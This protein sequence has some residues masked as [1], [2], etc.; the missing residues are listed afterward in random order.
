MENFKMVYPVACSG[1]FRLASADNSP[2]NPD[3]TRRSLLGVLIKSII[4]A[5]TLLVAVGAHAA[6][7]AILVLGDSISAEYGLPR[8]SG[9]VKQMTD[10]MRQNGFDYNVIN[11]SISGETTSGGQTR[12]PTLLRQHTPQLVIIELG[13]NDG[14]RG[15][16]LKAT[17]SN[18]RN[19]ITRSQKAGAKVLLVGMRLPPNYGRDYNTR[20]E[21]IFPKLATAH[22]TGLVKF[23]FEGFAEKVEM[24]Q[25]DRI[26][27]TVQ[28]QALLLN[29]IWPALKPMLDDLSRQARLPLAKTG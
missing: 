6:P 3:G 4:A 1:T 21:A 18:L 22:R 24:F 7:G 16:D 29:N 17:E 26:H 5:I 23:F 14:L 15:L 10:R 9:W 25:P 2:T 27:P 20:F 28:A 11:A 19:M 8:N 12:L 13:G